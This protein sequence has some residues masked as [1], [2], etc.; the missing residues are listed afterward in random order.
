[1]TRLRS[2]LYVPGDRPDRVAKAMA[3]TADAVIVDLE[4]AVKPASKP[5]ARDALRALPTRTA[6][7]RWVRINAGVDGRAD[8]LALSALADLERGEGRVGIDGVVVAKCETVDWLDEVAAAVGDRVAIAPLVE[9]ALA[10]RRLDAICAHQRTVQCQLGEVDLLADLGGRPPGGHA[11]VDRARLDLVVASAAA[12][13]AAPI[14][15]VHLAIDDLEA[16]RSTSEALADIGFAGRAIVHPTHCAVVNE[17]FSPTA[18]GLA[19]AEDVLARWAAAS[20]GAVRAADGSMIDEAV[21]RRA[22]RLTA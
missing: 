15:G 8:L 14:G 1:M 2:F 18:A 3:S 10:L 20:T 19:W 9:S 6:G 4:D 11:L 12:G 5:A 16:L 22:R 13:I 17:A 21:V 7:Q